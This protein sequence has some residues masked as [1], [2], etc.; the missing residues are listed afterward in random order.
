MDKE[1][2]PALRRGNVSGMCLDSVLITM[3]PV[4]SNLSSKL[5]AQEGSELKPNFLLSMPSKP[6]SCECPVIMYGTAVALRYE[7][8]SDMHFL[9]SLAVYL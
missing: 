8:V 2:A 7:S 5:M 9:L 3:L 4:L 1:K 6:P